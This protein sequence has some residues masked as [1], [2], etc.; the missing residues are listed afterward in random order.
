MDE[1]IEPA[2]PDGD[3]DQNCSVKILFDSVR[4]EVT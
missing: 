2:I 4:L 1:F 3:V